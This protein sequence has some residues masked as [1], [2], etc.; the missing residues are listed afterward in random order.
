[1]NTRDFNELSETKKRNFY[2]CQQCGEMVD[3]R[4]LDDVLFHEDHTHRPDIQYGGS[5][6]LADAVSLKAQ[7]VNLW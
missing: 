6:S 2:K 7:R 1:M 4:Q 3:K 5:Q